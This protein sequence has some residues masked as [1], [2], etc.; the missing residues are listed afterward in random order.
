MVNTVH[1]YGHILR[2]KDGH[3]FRRELDLEAEGQ[4]KVDRR[5]HGK[6]M[7]RRKV[8]WLDVAWKRNIAEQSRLLELI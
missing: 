2:R 4:R 6:R 5:G 1:C 7:L 3:V 8:S